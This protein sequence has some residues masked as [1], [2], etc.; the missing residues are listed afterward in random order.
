MLRQFSM[1]D[2]LI[3]I[4]ITGFSVAFFHAALPTHWLPFVLAGRGQGWG[5]KKTLVI[6]ALASLGHVALTVLLGALVVFLGIQTESWTGHVFPYVAGTVLILFGLYYLWRQ[7][8][9]LGGHHHWHVGGACCNDHHDHGH[10]HDH[11]HEK[12][13][14]HVHDIQTGRSDKAV[15]LG[16]M[17]LLTF[18]PCEGFLPVYLSG[19]GYEWGGFVMLSLILAIATMAGMVFF[20]WITMTGLAQVQLQTL[21]KY[22]AGL[23]GVLLCVLGILIMIIEGGH[24][25]H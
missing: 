18:S 9:G 14:H 23:L 21:E 8:K 1:N 6:T 7:R 4:A 2:M 20:T 22:E 19:I 11:A 16:L 3:T 15:I 10:A 17:A 25:G 12:H 24:H 5:Q 13:E